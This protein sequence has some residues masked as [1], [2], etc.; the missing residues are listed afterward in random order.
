MPI[1]QKKRQNKPVVA[2]ART[3]CFCL[4]REGYRVTS[5][6]CTRPLLA[7]PH[8]IVRQKHESNSDNNDFTMALDIHLSKPEW[9]LASLI[10]FGLLWLLSWILTRHYADFSPSFVLLLVTLGHAIH[11]FG[12]TAG[13][14]VSVLVAALF[15]FWVTSTLIGYITDVDRSDRIILSL[16]SPILALLSIFSVHIISN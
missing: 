5:S 12:F 7:V 8:L 11:I 16:S 2:T 9:S 6:S 13:G 15:Q 10:F 4:P 1:Q 3:P 14:F